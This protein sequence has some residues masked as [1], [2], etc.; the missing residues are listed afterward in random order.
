MAPKTADRTILKCWSGACAVVFQPCPA[1]RVACATRVK[2]LMRFLASHWLEAA[3]KLPHVRMSWNAT[4]VRTRQRVI[5]LANDHKKLPACL[6]VWVW[7]STLSAL[8]RKGVPL[9]R[10]LRYFPS[11]S[12]T[13]VGMRYAYF[14]IGYHLL[15][16][17]ISSPNWSYHNNNNNNNNNN[18][19]INVSKL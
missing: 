16:V 14:E 10:I 1:T 7:G 13:S 15:K 8:G 17:F 3:R 4:Y 12:A 6:L 19:F 5:P 18:N 9:I 2:R 11:V